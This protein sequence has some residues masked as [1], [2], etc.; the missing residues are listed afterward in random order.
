MFICLPS[1]INSRKGQLSTLM[2]LISQSPFIPQ[3]IAIWHL[4]PPPPAHLFTETA[5]LKIAQNVY[6][7]KS[8]DFL[9]GFILPEL[10]AML[11]IVEPPLFFWNV[12]CIELPKSSPLLACLPHSPCLPKSS[13]GVHFSLSSEILISSKFCSRLTSRLPLPAWF[14]ELTQFNPSVCRAIATTSLSVGQT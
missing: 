12:L 7:T 14:H 13:S 5:L 1:E 9:S 3:N 4:P 8:N 11:S 10:S 2:N 6:M